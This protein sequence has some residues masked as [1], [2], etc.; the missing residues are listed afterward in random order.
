MIVFEND[1]RI[2]K[3][4][5]EVFRYAG[6]PEHY[7][8]WNY[9]VQDVRRLS[10]G[11][12]SVGTRFRQHRR[13]DEQVLEITTFEP[14][15]RI[16]LRTV[17]PSRPQLLREMIFETDGKATRIVDRWQLKLNVPGL[18]EVVTRRRIREAVRENLGKLKTLLEAGQVVLQDGRISRLG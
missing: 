4:L 9:Y 14:E 13:E 17:P 5:D 8:A 2:E 12:I 11:P 7:P 6:D 1:V 10:E 16:E 3:P 15:H 18:I